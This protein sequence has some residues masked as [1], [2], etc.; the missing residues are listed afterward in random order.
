MGN[1][2]TGKVRLS[3]VNLFKP[4]AQVNEDGT[5]GAPKYSVLLLI[6]KSDTV[7]MDKL[8]NAEKVAQQE[9]MGKW[10]GKVPK[11]LKSIIHD[12]DEE[13][14]TEE[15]PEY[16]G[17]YFMSVTANAD[18][19]PKVVDRNLQPILDSTE[20]Y[21]GCYA[22]VSLRPF[23]YAAK[24]NNGVSFGLQNVQKLAD[25]EPLGGV[26]AKPEDEFEALGDDEDSLI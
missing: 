7:T 13:K 26:A 22:R 10:G 4:R 18:Y 14:D 16:A 25:G 2:V 1:V 8:R 20:V 17:H 6:P 24:G 3:F 12:G 9:G 11:N 15:Y 19:P 23:A 21:S 5:V